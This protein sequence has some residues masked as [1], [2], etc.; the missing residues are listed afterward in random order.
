MFGSAHAMTWVR[1]PGSEYEWED[2]RL[3][4]HAD[5]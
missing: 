1:W 5:V 4:S 3:V 2:G